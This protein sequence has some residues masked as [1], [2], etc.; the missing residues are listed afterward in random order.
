MKKYF[1]CPTIR[2][3]VGIIKCIKTKFGLLLTEIEILY[4]NKSV[5]LFFWISFRYSCA[6]FLVFLE[7]RLLAY[8]WVFILAVMFYRDICGFI[9][10]LRIKIKDITLYF[11]FP[12][13]DRIY[14]QY[15][16]RI[17]HLIIFLKSIRNT[18]NFS[19]FFFFNFFFTWR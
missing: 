12:F 14:Y 7:F 3:T 10:H 5:A 1:R 11:L 16:F 4:G 8:F 13:L 9:C 19:S 18:F 15:N 2:I 17:F 6:M